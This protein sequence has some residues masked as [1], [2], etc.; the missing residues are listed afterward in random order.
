MELLGNRI[1]VKEINDEV[2]KTGI[3]LPGTVV[4][5]IFQGEVIK[6]GPGFQ[7]NDGTVIPTTTKPGDVIVYTST[8]GWHIKLDGE[9]YTILNERDVLLIK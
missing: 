3:I 2:K 9:S 4:N 1:L 5:P 6:V 8:S 7:T